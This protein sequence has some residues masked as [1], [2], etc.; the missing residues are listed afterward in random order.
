MRL[1]FKNATSQVIQ[2]MS[3]RTWRRIIL[4]GE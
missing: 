2:K 4:S 3:H 1:A